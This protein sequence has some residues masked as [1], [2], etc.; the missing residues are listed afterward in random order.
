MG[1]TGSTHGERKRCMPGFGGETR[2]KR[3]YSEVKNSDGRIILKRI[4]D[5]WDGGINLINV[6]QNRDRCWA[7]L[8]AVINL[9]VP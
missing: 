5:K 8:N 3:V 6:D 1:R 9:P 4:V 7:L 2:G